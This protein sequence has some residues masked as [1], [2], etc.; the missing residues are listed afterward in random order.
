MSSLV[1]GYI[2]IALVASIQEQH[3]QALDEEAAIC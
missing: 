3:V 2:M 1:I